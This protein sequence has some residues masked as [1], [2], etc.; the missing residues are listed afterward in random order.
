MSNWPKTSHYLSLLMYP[1][2]VSLPF[3]PHIAIQCLLLLLL[4]L[5]TLSRRFIIHALIP[6]IGFSKTRQTTLGVVG[7]PKCGDFHHRGGVVV[8]V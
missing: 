3:D 1:A 8:G 2:R 4:L 7:R 5:Y 6:R